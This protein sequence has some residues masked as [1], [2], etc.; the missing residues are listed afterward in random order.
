MQNYNLIQKTLH[1]LCFNFSEDLLIDYN[2]YLNEIF[3]NKPIKA[4]Y[5]NDFRADPMQI[6]NETKD[7]IRNKE[8]NIKDYEILKGLKELILLKT[9]KQQDLGF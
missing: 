7:L 1:Y 4:D 2:K 6:L 5:K 9:R 3:F 8:L